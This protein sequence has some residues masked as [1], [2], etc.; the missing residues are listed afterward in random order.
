[1]EIVAGK[2]FSS[3][4]TLEQLFSSR[5][6]VKLLRLFL[7][8]PPR[9]YFIRE[10]VR[11]IDEHIN[12]VRRELMN[13]ERIGLLKASGDRLKK[14]YAVDETFSI[15]PE[16]KELFFKAQV[17]LERGVLDT[18][19][20]IG[21]VQL[22]VLTGFFAGLDDAQTDLLIVGSVNR[23]KLRRLLRKFQ[24]GIDREVTYT[25]MS[26]AE[27]RYRN[28]LTDRFLYHILEN[29]KIVVVDTL[30]VRKPRSAYAQTASA[31]VA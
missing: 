22:L 10:I 17:A 29:K 23:P 24:E 28:E 7:L 2:G 20:S 13:L 16:L 14:F 6:R 19:R 8:N 31:H 11:K 30:S 3:S 4:A 25:V 18:V 26:P 5:T 21:R 1:M 15:Y 9:P 12:S 27:F